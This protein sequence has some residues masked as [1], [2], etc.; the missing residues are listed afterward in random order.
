MRSFTNLIVSS[1]AILF[2]LFL[3]T[4]CVL[5]ITSNIIGQN[6][7]ILE[8]HWSNHWNIQILLA[9]LSEYSSIICRIIGILKYY[10]SNHWNPQISLVKLL[11]YWNII[12]QIIGN[13]GVVLVSHWCSLLVLR[14][15][16]SLSTVLLTLT[17]HRLL[18]TALRSV[19]GRGSDWLTPFYSTSTSTLSVCRRRFCGGA[20]PKSVRRSRSEA[21]RPERK[22]VGL[23]PPQKRVS[24]SSSSLLFL[25]FLANSVF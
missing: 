6:Y 25:F 21:T 14:S 22:D 17:G 20:R 13:I 18:F 23:A 24:S 4:A 9:E 1:V 8:H 2:L 12:G 5:N 16:W 11:E 3:L 19:Q 7:R 10:W 15:Y